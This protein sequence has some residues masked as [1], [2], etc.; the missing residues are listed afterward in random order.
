MMV[1][2][3]AY[4]NEVDELQAYSR[5]VTSTTGNAMLPGLL[6]D[7]MTLPRRYLPDT[8][9]MDVRSPAT[10]R[11][12]AGYTV[13]TFSQTVGDL[14]MTTS[15]TEYLRPYIAVVPDVARHSAILP[16]NDV[17]VCGPP[18]PLSLLA[19]ELS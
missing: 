1:P 7:M 5:A 9:N 8:T 3:K 18:C 11:P 13:V 10:V 15:A 16:G 12:S 4:P 6:K 17:L 14:G 2:N 19:E